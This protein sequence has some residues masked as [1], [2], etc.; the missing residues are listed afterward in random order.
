MK[1]HYLL[2][3]LI[4]SF[5]LV[6][7]L[8]SNGQLNN[9]NNIFVVNYYPADIDDF[10]AFAKQ[11]ARLLPYGRVD[12][13]INNAAEKADFEVPGNGGNWHEYA[14]YNKSVS[15]FFPDEKIAP[16]IPADFVKMNQDL[17][18]K[19][20]K[21]IRE[22]G[23]SASFRCNE[24]RYLPEAFFEKYPHLRGPRVDHPRRGS[25]AEFAPCFH[26]EE[27]VDMYRYMVG[28]FFAKAPEVHTLYFSMNDAGSGTCWAD[29]LYTG[30][31]GPVACK[32]QNLSKSIVTMLNVYKEAA[33]Q[34]GHEIDIFF[35]GMFTDAERDE[36]AAALPGRCYLRGR[37]YPSSRNASG[38]MG[39]T[40]PVRG[41]INP[42]SILKS[43]N[44]GDDSIQ[45]RYN[46]GFSAAYGRGHESL[47]VA[48]KL[49]DIID[50]QLKE[51]SGSS[52]INIMEALDELCV[53]WAGK[54]YANRLREAFVAMDE[55][56]EYKSKSASA[57]STLY[58]GVSTRHITRPLVFAP[59]HLTTEEETYFMPHVF[60]ISIEEA[61]ND[62]M[63]IHGGNKTLDDGV[64]NQFLVMLKKAYSLME[65]VKGAPEQMFLNDLAKSLRI[66][67]SVIRSCNNFYL[68][69]EIRN[70]NKEVLAGPIHRP[71]KIPTW[72]GDKDLQDF[73]AI[74]RDELDNAQELILL[75]ENGG[76]ELVCY[77]QKP[78]KEDTFVLGADLIQ[79]LKKKRNIM[80]THWTDIEGYL[81]TP[82][83]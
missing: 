23:L 12:V 38:M 36:V 83:K 57:L 17:L 13:G 3:S 6:S 48:E 75:L 10:E 43:L 51:P 44:R 68:A 40:Y 30:P 34:T 79:Q 9:E 18:D 55:A 28:R 32:D 54:E 31:N 73:N 39:Q 76:M 47:Q 35:D 71:D 26:Q 42:L 64:I 27:T 66:Y 63:D 8:R 78:F 15:V 77:A 65:E 82:F 60:N 7:N 2:L 67:A 19:K 59:K 5:L 22:L 25:K 61:R 81:A 52:E 80:L 45:H 1:S 56:F 16:F 33:K 46:L 62:Y 70:R 53:K 24:P 14:S 72:T 69:Q 11:L 58:W 49:I 74:M 21:I 41:I 37:N 29:W 4:A 50:W 20:L